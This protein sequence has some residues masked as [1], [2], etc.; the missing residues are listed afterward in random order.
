M[1]MKEK[2]KLGKYVEISI[3]IAKLSAK[4]DSDLRYL[5]IIYIVVDRKARGLK[6]FP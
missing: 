2:R 6:R 1:R 5:L 3:Q 4:K